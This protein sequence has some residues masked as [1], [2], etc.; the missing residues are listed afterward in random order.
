MEPEQPLK[1]KIHES[2]AYSRNEASNAYQTGLEVLARI[3]DQGLRLSRSNEH[4]TPIVGMSAESNRFI[5][6]IMNSLSS[7]RRLFLLLA[8]VTIII[9]Y[10]TLRWKSSR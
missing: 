2:L 6:T 4:L 3:R 10:L 7:G 8:I 9:L 5:G 1:R